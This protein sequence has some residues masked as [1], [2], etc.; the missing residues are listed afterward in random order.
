MQAR[1]E[2]I[3]GGDH[4]T[5]DPDVRACA[6]AHGPFGLM[7]FATQTDTGAED[8]GATPPTGR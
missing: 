4:S 1:E 2:M 3:L 7:H 5:S 6:G 8:S